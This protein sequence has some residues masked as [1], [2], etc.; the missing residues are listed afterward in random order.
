[1][2]RR[3]F[4]SKIVHDYFHDPSAMVGSVLLVIFIIGAGFAPWIA[5][6]NPYDLEKVSLEHFLTPPIWME[7]GKVPFL[8]GTDDQ[9]RG[10]FSTILYGC[11]TSLIVG[12]G[13]VLIAGTFGVTLGLL[14][15]YY[16]RT[17]DAVTMRFA[18][19]CGKNNIIKLFDH[20]PWTKFPQCPASLPRRALGMLAGELGKIF[21]VLDFGLQ[22]V[23]FFLGIH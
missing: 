22:R 6:Q 20:L 21:T 2:N 19:I 16:G 23:T 9:G 11:R 5:P 1:M 18:D 4:K 14:A 3:F 7:E 10:I 12:F 8:L 17:F 15:G 13:V